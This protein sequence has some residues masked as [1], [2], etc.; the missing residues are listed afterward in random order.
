MHLSIR[1]KALHVQR[2]I[3]IRPC[4][5]L[6]LAAYWIVRRF[7]YIT[8]FNVINSPSHLL[9]QIYFSSEFFFCNYQ[10]PLIKFLVGL[11]IKIRFEYLMVPSIRC[12]KNF[13][14]SIAG[15][16]GSPIPSILD[17]FRW[18]FQRRWCHR[19]R[20]PFSGLIVLENYIVGE[21]DFGN[22]K[23]KKG[24]ERRWKK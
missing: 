23:K 9:T 4:G 18:R 19:R 8:Q 5:R 17:T 22:E 3:A 13:K 11:D 16:K 12:S 1:G 21:M 2:S 6:Q 15:S 24:N 20:H 14:H 10:R 7:L